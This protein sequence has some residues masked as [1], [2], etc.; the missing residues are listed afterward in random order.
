MLLAPVAHLPALLLLVSCVG[1]SYLQVSWSS[2]F[3]P[4]SRPAA[5]WL[6]AISSLADCSDPDQLT[7]GEMDMEW[8]PI[9][10]CRSYTRYIEK[11]IAT[12]PAGAK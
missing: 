3:S 11:K 2:P 12:A 8:P 10:S 1:T 6:S 7:S 4:T 5:A 9:S